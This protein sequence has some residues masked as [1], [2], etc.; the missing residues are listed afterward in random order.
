MLEKPGIPEEKIITCLKVNYALDI[1][2]LTFLPL[3]A[4]LNSA[5]FQ[6]DAVGGASYFVKLRSGDFDE[7]TVIIPD[8]LRARGVPQVI[9]P[10]TNIAGKLRT[11]LDEFKLI[12]YPFISGHNGY[13]IKF[14]EE[15]WQV[16]GEALRRIHDIELPLEISDRLKSETFSIRWCTTL[17]AYLRD[18]KRI[19]TKESIARQVV[20]FLN[21][22]TEAI[23]W[24]IERAE[25]LALRLRESPHEN[26]LCHADMHAGNLLIGET[27]QVFIVDWDNPILAP[28]ERDLMFIA[29]AQGFKGWNSEEEEI[30]FYRGYGH[31]KTN[32]DILAYYR[33]ARII[34]DIALFYE[35]IMEQDGNREDR[36]QALIYLKSN[37][38]PGNTFDLAKRA[39]AIWRLG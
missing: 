36:E 31:V 3:G 35:Q 21:K 7:L 32:G 37:F 19:D 17:R 1:S 33:Y 18:L 22:K 26:V 4:D 28:R 30:L 38:L 2:G 20:E 29:N 14:S 24:L 27:G 10:I 5:V 16:F 39:E 6:A 25:Q 9:P 8:F 13:K 11:D 15:Q 23:T 12:L 34:E